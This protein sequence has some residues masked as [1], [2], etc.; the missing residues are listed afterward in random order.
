MLKFIHPFWPLGFQATVDIWQ[1]VEDLDGI[2]G[3]MCSGAC[4]PVAL[5][6]AAWNLPVVSYACSSGA[7]SNTEQYPTFV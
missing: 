2:I 7:L 4:Q 6:A 3:P 1:D 5:M